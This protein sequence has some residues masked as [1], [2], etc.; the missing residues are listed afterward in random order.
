MNQPAEPGAA[1]RPHATRVSTSEAKFILYAG[2]LGG[3]IGWVF[4]LVTGNPPRIPGADG[5]LSAGWH[6]AATLPVWVML[7]AAAAL[8][9]TILVANTDRTDRARVIAISM[10]SGM[11][12]MPVLSGSSELIKK[13]QDEQLAGEAKQLIQ[14]AAQ[15]AENAKGAQGEQR[16]QLL[17]SAREKLED[18]NELAQRIDSARL[19]TSLVDASEV[20]SELDV[21]LIPAPAP[22]DLTAPHTPHLV[23]AEARVPS[24][25]DPARASAPPEDEGAELDGPQATNTA[26]R[27]E[28][29]SEESKVS[30][31]EREE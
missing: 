6:L 14:D 28:D 24:L 5:T 3:I 17:R 12:W 15:I 21:A 13:H 2:A 4:G 11:F 22:I 10:L 19:A 8:I 29:T 26:A 7:G 9:F 20:L 25:E 31:A 1:Q 18:A 27:A 30:D 16:D 23:I